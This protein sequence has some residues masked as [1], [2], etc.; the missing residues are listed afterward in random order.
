[1]EKGK[2]PLTQ[3]FFIK[4]RTN[5]KFAK[6]ENRIRYNNFKARR[7]RAAKSHIDKLLDRNRTVLERILNGKD[8]AT[9]SKDF[10][11]GSGFFFGYFQYQRSIESIP[12]SGI[13][14]FGIARIRDGVFKIIK[15]KNG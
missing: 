14:E 10:L 6:P 12:Y 5:Q 15:F 1:M 11:L 2:D 3:E 4:K 13:Y 9:V 8:E 7:K